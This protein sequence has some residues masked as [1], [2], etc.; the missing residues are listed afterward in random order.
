MKGVPGVYLK[1][2]MQK[3]EG[4]IFFFFFNEGYTFLRAKKKCSLTISVLRN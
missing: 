3:L 1:Q 2:Y 4:L